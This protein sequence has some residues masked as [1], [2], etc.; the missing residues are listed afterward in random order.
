MPCYHPLKAWPVGFTDAGKVKYKV[1]AYN[2]IDVDAKIGDPIEVPC[3]KCIG[4]RLMYSRQ[5]ADRCMA[6]SLYHEYNYFLTLTY[7]DDH[8]PIS[9]YG[10][11]ETGEALCAQSLR[12]RD[13]QLWLKRFRKENGEGIRFYACGEYGGKTFRPHYHVLLFG[14]EFKDLCPFRYERGNWYYTSPS[15]MKSWNLGHSLIGEFSWEAA[16]YTARYVMKKA[17]GLSAAEYAQFNIEP[18]FVRMSRKPG[19]GKQF[20]EDHKDELYTFGEVNV[21]T[22]KGGRTIRASS[23][24]DRLYDLENHDHLMEIKTRRR[25]GAVAS[26]ESKLQYTSLDKLSYLQVQEDTCLDRSK[27]LIR[28]DV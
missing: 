11:P 14:H 1:T 15:L 9:Y 25:D 17:L 23:Y 7:D 4:C 24:F 13:L 5:W 28:E 22:L 8:V 6:E 19:I 16:A 12:A 10:D 3:G 2:V 27:K 26:M 20:Y 18:E 21:Q